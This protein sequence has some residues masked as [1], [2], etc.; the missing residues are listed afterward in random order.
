[1]V[2]SKPAAKSASASSDRPETTRSFVIDRDSDRYRLV[3]AGGSG[4]PVANLTE[5]LNKAG[6][7]CYRFIS[8]VYHWESASGYRVPIA[9]VE[10]DDVQHEYASFA[11]AGQ[12]AFI[13]TGTGFEQ[14]YREL[15]QRGFH[16]IDYH[17]IWVECDKDCGDDKEFLLERK[18]GVETPT[19]FILAYSPVANPK[20]RMGPE[21]TEQLKEKQAAGF[22]PSYVFSKWEI[23]LTKTAKSNEPSSDDPD[24][25]VVT[26][27]FRHD[28][29][30]KVNDLAK[31]GYRLVLVNSGI[32]VMSRRSKD[33]KSV[34]Y[35]WLDVD[36]KDFAKQLVELQGLGAVYQMPYPSREG[37]TKDKLIFELGA[38][39]QARRREYKVLEFEVRGTKDAAK[40]VHLDLTPASKET[41]ELLN[42]LAKD[43]FA[44]RD[45]LTSDRLRVILER[46]TQP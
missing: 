37:V 24:V 36:A 43:G 18:K 14:K 22:N 28:V 34:S 1:M 35:V 8:V 12:L 15:A 32:A 42:R 17:L 11:V 19:Q 41:M 38:K 27:S 9:I 13:I 23:L 5:Q 2:L 26:S 25:Q 20:A 30:E 10:R 39:D 4:S 29:R 40:K 7:Q 45:L 44:V 16:L 33:A 31:Q 3:L 6:E 46:S 21:L